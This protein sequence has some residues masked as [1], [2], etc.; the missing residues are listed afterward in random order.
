M[1]AEACARAGMRTSMHTYR[2][3]TQA[4][5]CVECNCMYVAVHEDPLFAGLIDVHFIFRTPSS[6]SPPHPWRRGGLQLE[7]SN[8]LTAEHKKSL[9]VEPVGVVGLSRYRGVDITFWE[10]DFAITGEILNVR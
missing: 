2:R 6:P 7:T 9:L 5:T 1:D 4:N 10:S 3:T 8:H